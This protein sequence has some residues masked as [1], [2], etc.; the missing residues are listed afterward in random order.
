VQA[1]GTAAEKKAVYSA[2]RSRYPSL[3]ATSTVIPTRGGSGR[4]YGQP[5]GSRNRSR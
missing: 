4:H 3:A 1:H 5:V 2:I